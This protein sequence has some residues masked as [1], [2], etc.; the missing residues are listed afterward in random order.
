MVRAVDLLAEA[1]LDLRGGKAWPDDLVLEVLV[2]RLARL[3]PLTTGPAG[4]SR[5]GAGS[6]CLRV[7]QAAAASSSR[8][9]RLDL[10]HQADFR[11][12][13]GS[14]GS[15]PWPPPVD[16]LDGQAQALVG[17]VG[18]GLGGRDR[19]LGAVLSS[20]RTA[21]LRSWRTRFCLLR[22]IWLLMFAT[23]TLLG[24]RSTAD[25]IE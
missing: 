11:G 8:P 3:A 2:A 18:T 5:A 24:F 1:D 4:G 22:L 7:G 19:G 16:A 10:G 6:R 13:P 20:E 21:L 9:R 14:C 23:G 12:R 25:D 17:I 15:R